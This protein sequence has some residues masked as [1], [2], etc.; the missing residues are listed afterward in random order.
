[1]MNLAI[2]R[3]IWIA[4]SSQVI[5]IALAYVILLSLVL[6]FGLLWEFE[7]GGEADSPKRI[8]YEFFAAS[9]LIMLWLLPPIA[10]HVFIEPGDLWA[11]VM[12]TL[13]LGLF[14]LLLSAPHITALWLGIGGIDPQGMASST[15]SILISVLAFTLLGA[16]LDKFSVWI[17]PLIALLTFGHYLAGGRIGRLLRVLSPLADLTLLSSTRWMN[18]G[19]MSLMSCAFALTLCLGERHRAKR[20]RGTR[21]TA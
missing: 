3:V 8:R 21:F 14:M 9:M 11:G 1:M 5:R 13:S 15:I 2:F 12:F 17:Y 18:L 4:Y 7:M 6:I 10:S 19:V 16:C 20:H